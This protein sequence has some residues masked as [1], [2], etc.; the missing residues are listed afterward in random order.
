MNT[1]DLV[2]LARS[3]APLSEPANSSSPFVGSLARICELL[4]YSLEPFC[5]CLFDSD[6]TSG[7]CPSTLPLGATR[8]IFVQRFQSGDWKTTFAAKQGVKANIDVQSGLLGVFPLFV[9]IND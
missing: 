2:R 7:R 4:P 8:E 1:P 9:L 6:A 5:N 3:A